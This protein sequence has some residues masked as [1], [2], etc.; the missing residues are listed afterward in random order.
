MLNAHEK[1]GEEAVIKA[2]AKGDTRGRAL[3]EAKKAE[4]MAKKLKDFN[5]SDWTQT[6]FC[7][8]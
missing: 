5:S 7:G 8:C 4:E 6:R 2:T 3:G 1:T